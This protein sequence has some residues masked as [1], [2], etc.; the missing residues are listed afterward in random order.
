MAQTPERE[1]A[2]MPDATVSA[3]GMRIVKLLVGQPP[4]TIAS[5]IAGTGVTRTAI[6]EQLNELVASGFVERTTQRLASR[7]RPRHLYAATDA[8]LLLLFTTSQRVV[9]PAIWA[10]IA[11]V[12]GKALTRK[13]IRRVSLALA[14]HYKE[15]IAG[16]TPHQRLT[17]MCRILREEGGLV[18]IH[19]D[20][21]GRV[22]LHKRSCPFISLFD[23]SRTV[24]SLD[25]ELMKV[26]VGARVR[27][28]AW[29]HDG[30]PCCVFR[31]ASSNGK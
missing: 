13:I 19:E 9:V 6:T 1:V 17:E 30:A 14:N 31:L 21:D 16:E 3:P 28:T 5:L 22:F 7:G 29:R 4:Q 24:C 10:A 25:E 26:V 27:R 11:H 2:R 20:D 18:D 12:G 8:A 15:Q 23:E